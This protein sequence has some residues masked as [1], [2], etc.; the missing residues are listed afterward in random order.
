MRERT[1]RDESNL[2]S[3]FQKLESSE[4]FDALISTVAGSP[5]K[6]PTQKV[7]IEDNENGEILSSVNASHC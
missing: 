2:F 5:N 4:Y 1:A 3:V 7:Y 6:G